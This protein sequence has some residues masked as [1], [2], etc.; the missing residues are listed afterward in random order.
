MRGPDH[1]PVSGARGS[2]ILSHHVRGH[3]DATLIQNLLLHP[4]LFYARSFINARNGSQSNLPTTYQQ[5]DGD[6]A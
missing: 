1:D 3:V 2:G 5:D 6:A 4:Y